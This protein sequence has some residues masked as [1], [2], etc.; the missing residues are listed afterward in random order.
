MQNFSGKLNFATNMWTSPNHKAYVALTVHLEHDGKALS[1]LLDIVEV[2]RSHSGINLVI[3]LADVLQTFGIEKKVWADNLK[4]KWK[5]R[6]TFMQILSIMADNTS[7][8]D[9][10][11]KQ[12]G[13]ILDS[14]PGAANQTHCFAHTVNITAKAILK[15]FDVPKGKNDEFLDDAAQAFA[16]LVKELDIEEQSTQETQDIKDDKDDNQPLDSWVDFHGG[17]TDKEVRELDANIQP[18]QLML[19]KVCWLCDWP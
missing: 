8:N 12:L 11:V 18:V 14:F 10:M 16:D 1:L 7:N 19:I 6:L 15:Q 17:L 3:V 13:V 4:P 2:A 9:T 5:E